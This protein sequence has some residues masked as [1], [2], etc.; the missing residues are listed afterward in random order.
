MAS[1]DGEILTYRAE[2]AFPKWMKEH[3]PKT[4]RDQN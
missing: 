4:Y 3:E 1:A 2:K